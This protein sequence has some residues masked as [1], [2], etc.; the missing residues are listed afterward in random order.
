MAKLY[1]VSLSQLAKW[2]G[3]S[4]QTLTKT[5]HADSLQGDLSYFERIARLHLVL[6]N[7]NFRKWLRLPN[8]QLANEKPLTWIARKRWQPLADLVD[9]MLTGAPT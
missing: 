9:D 5:P 3:R 1:G 2:L 8:P 4:R 6:G 7:S